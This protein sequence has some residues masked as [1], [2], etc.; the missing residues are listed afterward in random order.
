MNTQRRKTWLTGAAIVLA[1]AALSGC[2]NSD[3][4]DEVDASAVPVPD[5]AGASGTSFIAYIKGLA[6]GDETSEP[7]T[8]NA[9]FTAPAEDPAEPDPVS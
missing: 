7:K 8:F 3:R 2:W 6:A 4:D 9:T 5:S 1:A